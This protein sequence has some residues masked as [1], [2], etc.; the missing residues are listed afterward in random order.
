[1]PFLEWTVSVKRV[2]LPVSGCPFTRDALRPRQYRTRHTSVMQATTATERRERHV[3]VWAYIDAKS[4]LM[5]HV[6]ATA[7]S[8]RVGIGKKARYAL[9]RERMLKTIDLRAILHAASVALDKW[10]LEHEPSSRCDCGS[11]V[12][13]RSR[14]HAGKNVCYPCLLSEPAFLVELRAR[15]AVASLE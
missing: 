11:L 5:S 7:I 15:A 13:H 3:L 4:K 8:K 9:I 10:R 12:T 2:C 14:E 1:M 6:N